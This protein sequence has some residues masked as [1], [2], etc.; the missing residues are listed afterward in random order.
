MT[1]SEEDEAR[2]SDADGQIQL[3]RVAS[4]RWFVLAETEDGYG[5]W[6]RSAGKDSAPILEFDED[7][8]G[9]VEAD[10]EYRR[11]SR[12]MRLF[13]QLPG[14]LA[15]IVAIGV[16]QWFVL[17]A[18]VN[19]WSLLTTQNVASSEFDYWLPYQAQNLVQIAYALWLGALGLM[20]MLWLLRR[21]REEPPVV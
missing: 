10:E 11:R 12:Q 6:P 20:V 2:P 1:G 19:I 3:E 17:T 4:N 15:W 18:Y 16:I 5:I 13:T 9:F 21:S 14:V 8:D 7:A